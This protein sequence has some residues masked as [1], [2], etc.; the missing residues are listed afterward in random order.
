MKEIKRIKELSN[1]T[2]LSKTDR[3]ALKWA[4]QQLSPEE[5]SPDKG[6]DGWNFEA[7]PS[8]PNQA[9]FE[10]LIKARK[11]KH[12][13]IMTQAYI[14]SAA[15]HL[16]ELAKHGVSVSESVRMAANNGWQ[17]FRA[18]WVINSLEEDKNPQVLEIRTVADAWQQIKSGAITKAS[19]LSGPIRSELET[20]IRTGKFKKS[21]SLDLLNKV[22][23]II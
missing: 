14:D 3:D 17:G 16:H 2:H 1:C 12:K 4:L 21:A 7:W 18:K 9:S 20:M 10:E 8:I 22:G 19:E 11:A 15:P 23:I 6:F 13:V 5:V